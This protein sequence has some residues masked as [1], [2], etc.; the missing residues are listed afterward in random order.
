MVMDNFTH[1]T[2]NSCRPRKSCGIDHKTAAKYNCRFGRHCHISV[3]GSVGSAQTR[4]VGVS[5]EVILQLE[6]SNSA[7]GDGFVH[8]VC[9]VVRLLENILTT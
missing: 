1:S 4:P 3:Y 2:H 7:E 9:F 6:R 5:E 8:S